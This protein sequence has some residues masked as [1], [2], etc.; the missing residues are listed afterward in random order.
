MRAVLVSVLIIFSGVGQAK[1]L[2]FEDLY[3]GFETA[4]LIPS[5]Y[6]GLN[7]SSY[8]AF[9]TKNYLP[10]TGYDVGTF[11]RV[12]LFTGYAVAIEFGSAK[13]FDFNGAYITSAWDSTNQVTVLGYRAGVVV[14]SNVV[15]ARNSVATWFALNFKDVDRIVMDPLGSHIVIDNL[16][17][18][19]KVLLDVK[20]GSDENPINISARGKLPVAI[21]A[22]DAPDIT[23]IDKASLRIAGVAPVMISMSDINGDGR[24]DIVM[25]F[26]TEALVAAKSLSL[27]TKELTINGTMLGGREAIKGSDKVRPLASQSNK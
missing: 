25:H 23:Q 27:T 11:G 4:N 9:I 2:D 20:P 22:S 3:P 24:A 8:S 7:W 15:T 16:T 14:Y 1:V 17:F 26:S 19:E 6:R 13:T 10:G 18:T 12:S 21:L 5:G